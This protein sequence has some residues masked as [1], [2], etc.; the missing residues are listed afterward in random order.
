MQAH[1]HMASPPGVAPDRSLVGGMLVG[2]HQQRAHATP[3]DR[4]G[5]EGVGAGQVSLLTQQYID[6]LPVLVYGPVQVHPAPA[7]PS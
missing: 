4:L 7:R 5:E 1:P 2:D 3:E 6:Q